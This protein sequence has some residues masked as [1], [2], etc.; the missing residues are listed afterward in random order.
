MQV[1]RY[2]NSASNQVR[3]L[4]KHHKSDEVKLYHAKLITKNKQS[5]FT[6]HKLQ[7]LTFFKKKENKMKKKILLGL[8]ICYGATLGLSTFGTGLRF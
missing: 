8:A 1:V 4:L 6:C 2:L 7:F 3:A 5:Q